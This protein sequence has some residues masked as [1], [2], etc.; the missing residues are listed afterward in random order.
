MANAGNA[1]S[2]YQKSFVCTRVK[3]RS[4]IDIHTRIKVSSFERLAI[5]LKIQSPAAN[6]SSITQTEFSC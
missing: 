6:G 5:A 2:M 1:G 3:K 4:T